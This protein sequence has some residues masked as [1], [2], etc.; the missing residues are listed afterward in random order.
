MKAFQK[1]RGYLKFGAYFFAILFVSSCIT[2]QEDFMYLNDQVVAL[3]RRVSSLQESMDKNLDSKLA[4]IS[5]SQAESVAEINKIKDEI[6]TLT[7]RIEENDHLLRRAVEKDTTEVDLMKASLADL[8]ERVAEVEDETKKLTQYLGLELAVKKEKD[9]SPLP[10]PEAEQS[11]AGPL[12]PSKEPVSPEEKLYETTLDI[13]NKG[14]YEKAIAGFKDFLKKYP[15][16]NL[17]DN[18]QFWIGE[19]YMSLKQYESAILAYQEVIKKYPKGNKIPNALLR[20]ALAF[21]EIK[22]KISSRL[23]LKKIIKQY[24][25]SSEAKIAEIRLKSL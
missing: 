21:Y 25:D 15:D 10:S 5:N 11:S 22:D 2:T 9:I 16:S 8:A 7:G 4:A 17:A 19:S 24:P 3:N 18:A 13:Y 20:Q 1:S 6:Q 12:T 23:L 14:E